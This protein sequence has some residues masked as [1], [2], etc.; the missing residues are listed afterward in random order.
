M[1]LDQK[2][3]DVLGGDT[4]VTHLGYA[5]APNISNR[6]ADREGLIHAILNELLA[7]LQLPARDGGADLGH[8]QVEPRLGVDVLIVVDEAAHVPREVIVVGDDH[9]A[10]AA[11]KMLVDVQAEDAD[12]ADRSGPAIMLD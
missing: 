8:A 9:A 4:I 10:L 2:R 5:D 1:M 6:L 11:V 12:V 7:A 3:N